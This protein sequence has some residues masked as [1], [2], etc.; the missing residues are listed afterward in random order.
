MSAVYLTE[1]QRRVLRRL[2]AGACYLHGPDV[3][4]G[5][6]LEAR[7]LVTIKDRGAS[8]SNGYMPHDSARWFATIT[9]D[10]LAAEKAMYP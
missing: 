6:A 4:I 5:K 7:A 9:A 8:S 3:R 1:G 2:K 10:G